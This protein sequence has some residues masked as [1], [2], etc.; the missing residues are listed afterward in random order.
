MSLLKKLGSFV[1]DSTKALAQMPKGVLHD[2][3]RLI[4]GVDPA[5][6][7][8]WNGITGSD[9]APLVN[10]F[11]GPT[12]SQL[13][14]V[15]A[16]GLARTGFKV[17]D[18]V[19]GLYGGAGALSGLGNAVGARGGTA[20]DAT[21]GAN[22]LGGTAALG[23]GTGGGSS[24]LGRIGT[25]AAGL[26]GGGAG[27]S[28]LGP[29]LQAGGAIGSAALSSSAAKKATAADQAGYD[30][31]MLGQR[32]ALGDVRGIQQPYSDF[33]QQA[34]GSLGKVNSGDYS[35]FMNSP[36]YQF[37][38]DQGGRAVDRSAAARGNLNSGN[39]LL[40]QQ[41]FGQGLA[42]QNLNNYRNSLFQQLGVGQQAANQNT[43]ATTGIAGN[44]SN[45]AIGAGDSRASGITAQ[46]NAL[47]NGIDQLGHLFGNYFGQNPGTNV[48]YGYMGNPASG[49]WTGTG[50][51]LFANPLGSS[52]KIPPYT[53]V[54]GGP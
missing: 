51:A 35:G 40:A 8:L 45:M 5:S 20:A 10:M 43:N 34:I 46:G 19:A 47:T 2:P 23:A 1:K 14:A 22:S 39:T 31:A 54:Y 26:L 49:G 50:N 9:K 21:V 3:S 12:G 6:T 29:L 28:L 33:G 13:D 41:R 27:G 32:Q 37:A 25:G 16:G 38:L 44:I 36:D 7:K 53:Y 4:T 15:N 18:T 42:T 11:G 17:A 30:Q 48:N 52:P 24:L